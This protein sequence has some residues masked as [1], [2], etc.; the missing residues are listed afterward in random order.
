MAPSLFSDGSQFPH[1]LDQSNNMGCFDL[2]KRTSIAS[3]FFFTDAY[4]PL[5]LKAPI[6]TA[7][8]NNFTFIYL[9]FFQRI[10]S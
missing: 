7:A 5:T 2:Q 10:K 4:N 9:F 8:E 1:P 6:T 3:L